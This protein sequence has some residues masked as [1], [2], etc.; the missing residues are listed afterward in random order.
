[1]ACKDSILSQLKKMNTLQDNHTINLLKIEY[2]TDKKNQQIIQQ[3]IKIDSQKRIVFFMVISTLLLLLVFYFILSK[4][5][6][7]KQIGHFGTGK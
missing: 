3:Q 1:M 7:E 4:P 6:K 2:E 5:T